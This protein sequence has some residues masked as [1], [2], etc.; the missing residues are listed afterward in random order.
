MAKRPEN[1]LPDRE[2]TPPEELR[3]WET[4]QDNGADK[5]QRLLITNG[6]LYRTI[7]SGQVALVFVQ[8][9]VPQ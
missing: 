7:V 3:D 4:V 6:W 8:A 9:D 2:R 1:E 5:T